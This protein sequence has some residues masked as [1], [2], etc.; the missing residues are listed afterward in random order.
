MTLGEKI[1]TL[2]TERGMSQEAFG[3]MLGVS[4]QS[5]SKWETDQSVPELDKIVAI[6]NVFTVST[7]YLLKETAQRQSLPEMQRPVFH[8]EYRSR[9]TIKGVPLV[10]VNF[11]LRPVCA[12]GIIAIGNIATGVVAIGI[13]GVGVIALA[14]VAVG[15]LLALGALTVGGMAWGSLAIGIIAGGAVSFGIFSMGGLAVGQF[16]FGAMALGQQV[17]IGDVAY[18]NIALGFSEAHGT[19]F[20]EI[21]AADG[22]FD[23]QAM[24]A[25]IDANVAGYWN[26]F[27]GWMKW[28]IQVMV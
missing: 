4:R 2:R 7:D 19:I 13:A 28:L 26:I 16:S 8:Y 21:R 6:S 20:E 1:Y 10:H 5:V 15:L 14:P 27:A 18:G 9:K 24:L 3:E 12:K 22:S 23:R 11:G 25:A 17:A